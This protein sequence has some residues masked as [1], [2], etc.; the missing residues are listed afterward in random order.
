[1]IKYLTWEY[2]EEVNKLVLKYAGKGEIFSY[3]CILS[4]PAV[5]SFVE[6]NFGNDIFKKALAY[7][8]S[9][10]VLHPFGEGNHRT[11]MVAAEEFLIRNG[12][13]S[14]ATNR[15]RK[16]L[17]NWRLKYGKDNDLEKEFFR[18]SNMENI[19]QRNNEIIKVMNSEYG[20]RI[21]NWLKKRYKVKTNEPQQ[22][23]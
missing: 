12:Y 14:N 4:I 21:E 23:I 15:E 17:L 20:L 19:N 7:C 22:N 2:L 5:C 9:L 3:D 11:S 6:N 13:Y 16:E 8:V 18:I 1:M 10:I